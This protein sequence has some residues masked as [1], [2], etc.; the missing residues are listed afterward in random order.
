MTS[1]CP[2]CKYKIEIPDSY[3]GKEI[4]CPQCKKNYK[5]LKSEFCSNCG[6][7]LGHLEQAYIFNGRVVCKECDKLLCEINKTE[8]ITQIVP[9]EAKV[10]K[11]PDFIN[12][13][14]T[15]N[16]GRENMVFSGLPRCQLCGGYM[17]KKTISKGNASGIALALLTFFVGLFISLAFF[18][19]GGFLIGIPLCICALFMGGKRQKVL[20]CESCGAIVER[21]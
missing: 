7:S 5:Y 16:I 12:I 10:I 17:N 21:G 4:K 11:R 8:A 1:E 19:C 18:F 14:R 15:G 13:A 3:I 9:V 20:K 2:H 6:R